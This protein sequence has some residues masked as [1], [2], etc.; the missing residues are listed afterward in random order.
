AEGGARALPG[1]VDLTGQTTRR[2]KRKQA[3]EAQRIKL[4]TTRSARLFATSQRP[5]VLRHTR[6]VGVDPNSRIL[7]RSVVPVDRRPVE[8]D[9]VATQQG[10]SGRQV[11]GLDQHIAGLGP[12]RR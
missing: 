11:V 1:R 7:A 6:V 10:E 2:S 9:V 4:R 5:G 3:N 12:L 8:G